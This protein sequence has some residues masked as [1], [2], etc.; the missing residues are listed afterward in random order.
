M[1]INA[2][3]WK[4]LACKEKG[5]GPRPAGDSSPFPWTSAGRS[6]MQRGTCDRTSILTHNM[7]QTSNLFEDMTPKHH[8]HS[9]IPEADRER[10]AACAAES[11]AAPT[12][13]G[14]KPAIIMIQAAA[15]TTGKEAEV[16]SILHSVEAPMSLDNL[17]VPGA[18]W[19][20]AILPIDARPGEN[21]RQRVQH[22]ISRVR[23]A[24][25][26]LGQRPDESTRKVWIAMSQPP[27]RQRRASLAA[28]VKQAWERG[29]AGFLLL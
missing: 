1:Q 4:W 14:G 8:K 23:A 18:R 5:R 13:E 29:C 16:H 7:Q 25:V 10:S 9:E 19:R 11:T 12:S 26:Q 17:F 3:R 21:C 28:K 6:R 15:S 24:N 27:E 2:D 22:A 20:Y